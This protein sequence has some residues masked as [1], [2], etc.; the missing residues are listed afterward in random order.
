MQ[1]LFLEDLENVSVCKNKKTTMK[2]PNSDIQT[3]IGWCGC[4][5]FLGSM[6]CG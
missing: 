2:N 6:C 4:G 3:A 1:H 5:W